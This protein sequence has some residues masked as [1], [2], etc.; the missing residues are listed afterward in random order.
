MFRHDTVESR[1]NLVVIKD[2]EY[3]VIRALVEF[4]YTGKFNTHSHLISFVYIA[5][6]KYVVDGLKTVCEEISCSNISNDSVKLLK[7][8]A[9]SI[10]ANVLLAQVLDFMKSPSYVPEA[11]NRLETLPQTVTMQKDEDASQDLMEL[12]NW[13]FYCTLLNL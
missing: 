2:F 11:P 7:K 5:A 4:M 13:A 8:L 10:G 6:D 12:F 1:N 3:E 9:E